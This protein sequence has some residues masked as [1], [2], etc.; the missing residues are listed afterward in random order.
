MLEE[1]YSVESS[2]RPMSR[3][4]YLSDYIFDFTTYDSAISS[5]MAKQA[6]IIC[7]VI[8][9]S[10]MSDYIDDPIQYRSFIYFCNLPFFISKLDWGTSI[11]FPWWNSIGIVFNSTGLWLNGEQIY[12]NLFFKDDEWKLAVNDML[13]FSQS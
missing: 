1:G 5:E 9:D 2:D 12:S 4:E 7:K 11:R 3:L 13:E 10:S 8:N 6:L